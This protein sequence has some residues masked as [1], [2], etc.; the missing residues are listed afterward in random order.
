MYLSRGEQ[1]A[2]V[3]LLALFLTGAGVL[4]YRRGVA[5]GRAQV[6]APLFVEA[7]ASAPP[8]VSI[9]VPAAPAPTPLASTIITPTPSKIPL[10][11]ATREQLDT[12]P[13]I[14]PVLAQR[15]LDYREAQRRKNGKGFTSID[16]LL[17]VSGIGPKRMT[18]IRELVTL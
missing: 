8:P 13:G 10:N 3:L 7:S 15:I 17:N 2:L 9:G 12:L 5:A 4:T 11:T 18:A 14:G 6:E 1:L 16:E